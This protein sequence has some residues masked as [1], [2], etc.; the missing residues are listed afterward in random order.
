MLGRP[1]MSRF[2]MMMKLPLPRSVPPAGELFRY[3]VYVSFRVN[4]QNPPC[5]HAYLSL[6]FAGALRHSTQVQG[7]AMHV[8]GAGRTARTR[9]QRTKVVHL[10]HA[11]SLGVCRVLSSIVRRSHGLCRGTLG[12]KMSCCKRPAGRVRACPAVVSVQVQQGAPHHTWLASLV[13]RPETWFRPRW[14]PASQ[15]SACRCLAHI[16]IVRL[17]LNTILRLERL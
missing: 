6:R 4:V 17:K 15:R 11:K 1:C 3:R 10:R 14:W 5:P 2:S 12:S 16:C 9:G 7:G 13:P 8:Y